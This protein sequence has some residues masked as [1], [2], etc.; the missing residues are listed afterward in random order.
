[1]RRKLATIDTIREINPIPGADAIEVATVRGWKVV[2]KKGEFH[3]GDHCV[4]CEVDSNLPLDNPD[5]EFL[6]ARANG[7]DRFRV[8]TIKLR[9]QISQG[10]VFS[11]SILPE[12]EYEVGTDVTEL[13]NIE[14]YE[15]PIPAELAGNVRGPF[16]GV[17]SKTDE[18][19]VQN[20]VDELA[21]YV[22]K[23]FYVTEKLDGSSATYYL[24]NDQFGACSRNWDL[25]ES[26]SNT[27]WRVAR[28][29]NLEGILRS[30]GEYAI[31][32]ELVGPGIQ[33]NRLNRPKHELYVFRV[34]DLAAGKVLGRYE[35][36]EFC[37]KNGLK[38]VPIVAQDSFDRFLIDELV[39]F[40][41]TNSTLN[42]VAMAEGF[43][44]RTVQHNPYFSFKVLNPK[45]L[46]KHE[47]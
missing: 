12:G 11:T 22:G 2:V 3:V 9:G 35:M 36:E 38:L 33:K 13:L 5:F 20:L 16:P 26:E 31:Q 29:L 30:T 41:T 44:F 21:A 1:M 18:E 19:R 24:F 4:Y 32:G 7:R 37:N 23:V 15:A 40:A 10:I 25:C 39:E 45:Y 46:L 6:R 42:P 34:I 14:K 47:E 27:F 8:R 17:I 28:E 43:V